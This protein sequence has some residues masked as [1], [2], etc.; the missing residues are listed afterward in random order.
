MTE[1]NEK[2]IGLNRA[3]VTL[4]SLG[5]TSTVLMAAYGMPAGLMTLPVVVTMAGL[6]ICTR[7]IWHRG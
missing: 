7:W 1:N 4:V 2:E 6:L 5:L 3:G